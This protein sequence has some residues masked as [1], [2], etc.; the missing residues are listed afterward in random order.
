MSL[1][2]LAGAAIFDGTRR[3][4]N[5]AVLIEDRVIRPVVETA[6]IPPDAM[7]ISLHGGQLAPS[8]VGLHL[9]GPHLA[10][11][12]KGAHLESMLRPLGEADVQRLVGTRNRIE[13]LFI[14]VAPEMATPD[15][16]RHLVEAGIIVGL[17]DSDADYETAR[18][19]IEAGASGGPHLF[20]AMSQLGHRAPGKVG[21][22]L[23]ADSIA[24]GVIADGYHVDPASL[25]IAI[26]AKRG[27]GRLNLITEA[28]ALV[29]AS[30]G[31][32]LLNGREVR[33]RE[34]RLT[35]PDGTLAG[36]DLTMAAAVRFA[37][38]HLDIGFGGGLRMASLYSAT[39]LGLDRYRGRVAPGFVAD[40]VHLDAE[41][42][43]TRIWT[44]GVETDLGS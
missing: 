36:S 40:L 17:G 15:R 20:I 42:K 10:P 44:A 34:G 22:L 7:V 14:T 33:R 24:C 4:D 43:V 38:T 35:F 29:G 32:F 27:P 39:F 9:E 30:S 18:C 8:I 5:R 21:A 1:V 19:A 6:V 41:L 16:I 37:V 23:D 25:R 3:L 2:A 31:S 13:L 26:R 28:M 12:R 11:K